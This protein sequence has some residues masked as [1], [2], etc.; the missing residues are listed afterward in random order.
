MYA[1][2]A[3]QFIMKGTLASYKIG[4]TGTV[5]GITKGDLYAKLVEMGLF[6]GKEIK[7]L[8]KAP[9]GDPIAVDVDGYVLSLRKEEADLVQVES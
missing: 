5:S 7:V 1:F 3:R 8:F 4:Q 6:A 9:F 2:F